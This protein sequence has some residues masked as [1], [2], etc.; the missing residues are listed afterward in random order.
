MADQTATLTT[1]QISTLRKEAEDFERKS[2]ELA[3]S[4]PDMSAH[5]NRLFRACRPMLERIDK[6]AQIQR[7][8][9]Q[10]A[11]R[12]EAKENGKSKPTPQATAQASRQ[13]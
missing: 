6:M 1:E 4:A 11:K 3:A 2:I 13:Q 8:K 9:S 5:Y 12:K 7:R 10:A